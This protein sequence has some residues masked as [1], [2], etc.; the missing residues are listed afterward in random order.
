MRRLALLVL[1]SLLLLAVPSS[2]ALAGT[3]STGATTVTN[4]AI[5]PKHATKLVLSA[6]VPRPA[7][8]GTKTTVWIWCDNAAHLS[9][10]SASVANLPDGGPGD[11]ATVDDLAIPSDGTLVVGKT[12]GY[13]DTLVF[14]SAAGGNCWYAPAAQ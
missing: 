2:P 1:L 3:D 13:Q 8:V 14:Y 7:W 6:G 11:P 12:G 10:Q 9:T 5:F 4:A